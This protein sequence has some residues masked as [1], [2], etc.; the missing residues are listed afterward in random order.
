MT[1]THDGLDLTI[2]GPAS[3]GHGTS[4]YSAPVQPQPQSWPQMDVAPHCT[5]SPP[6]PSSPP[7][8]PVWRPVQISSLEDPPV[9]TSGG[10]SRQASSTH[11]TRML[12]SVLYLRLSPSRGVVM[13]TTSK[14]FDSLS[15]VFS[16]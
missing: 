12:S 11:P 1:I 8:S 14:H 15:Y 2:Q 4:L 6:P 5:G 10:Y 7:G 16:R 13:L 3:P 9:M